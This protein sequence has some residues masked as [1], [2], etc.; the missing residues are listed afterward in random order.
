MGR[1]P[2]LPRGPGGQK[3]AV[4]SRP[5]RGSGAGSWEESGPDQRSQVQEVKMS[6]FLA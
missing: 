4:G 6:I 2:G 5:A 1:G 3:A